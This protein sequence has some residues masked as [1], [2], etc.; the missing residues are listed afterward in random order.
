MQNRP[1]GSNLTGRFSIFPCSEKNLSVYIIVV[2]RIAEI[3]WFPFAPL[4]WSVK[5]TIYRYLAILLFWLSKTFLI[6]PLMQLFLKIFEDNPDFKLKAF[7]S[8]CCF[9]KPFF[10][11]RVYFVVCW[12]VSPGSPWPWNFANSLLLHDLLMSCFGCSRRHLLW[13]K[14]FVLLNCRQWRLGC[15]R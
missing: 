6:R 9:R 13:K 10:I 1:A 14:G 2:L 5:Y 15:L 7:I 12:M 8:L 4:V 3:S 11:Q